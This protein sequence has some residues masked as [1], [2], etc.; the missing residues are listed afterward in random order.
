MSV[1][2]R[3]V[4][5]ALPMNLY[6]SYRTVAIDFLNFSLELL[7]FSYPRTPFNMLSLLESLESSGS[8]LRA[9]AVTTYITSSVSLFS[10]P[11]RLSAVFS[12]DNN[13]K[14]YITILC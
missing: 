14:L 6:L 4:D 11:R 5:L 8:L 9:Y 3:Y 2:N 10:S 13:R 7:S 12:S 1:S